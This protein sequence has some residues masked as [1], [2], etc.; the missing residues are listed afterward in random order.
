[1]S[2]YRSRTFWSLERNP[3][4]LKPAS[5]MV[6]LDPQ[7]GQLRRHSSLI[8]GTQVFVFSRY[9]RQ[10]QNGD[11]SLQTA[12]AHSPR[13][14]LCHNPERGVEPIYTASQRLPNVGLA[15]YLRT[16]SESIFVVSGL[17]DMAFVQ[18]LS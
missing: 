14:Q 6:L 11:E 8:A 4:D 16:M 3:Q 1:M 18:W 15:Q 9:Q 7:W 17:Q 5:D 2:K 13:S 10:G 12:S